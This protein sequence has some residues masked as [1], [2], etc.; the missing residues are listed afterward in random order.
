MAT[1]NFL[2]R[3]SVIVLFAISLLAGSVYSQDIFIRVNQA[4]YL[5]EDT[6]RAIAF[7]RE[8]LRD[9]NFLVRTK[10]SVMFVGKVR[11]I[12]SP[13]WGGNFTYFYELDLS[14]VRNVGRYTIQLVN[15]NTVSQEFQ[16]GDYPTYQE[17]LLFFMRQQRCGYNPFLDAVCHKRDGRS[18]YAPFPDGTFVD[19]SGGWH[20]AGDQ[21]KY[22]ITASNA[23]ARMMLAYELEKRKFS[24]TV[25]ALG[26][27]WPNGIPD[28][29]DEAKWGLD[30]IHKLHPAKD[31][32]I[33]QVADDR[34]HRG[35]KLPDQDNADY[36][37]GPNSYRPAYFADGK[38]QGLGQYKSRSTGVANIAG[39]SAAAMA[40]ADRLWR[41]DIKDPMFAAE[42]LKD[43]EELYANGQATGRLST[44]QFVRSS[45]PLQR[46]YLGGRYGMGRSGII[47]IDTKARLFG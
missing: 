15:A 5:P 35:F 10:S 20:D 8:P 33:H 18:F 32:L 19:A 38:P 46:R 13:G 34:D 45:L 3:R 6:K 39:R 25:D 30:W 40:M 22:L 2:T 28:V 16:I 47:Q 24:D 29:L 23:T 12:A 14:L 26:R 7:S 43:A 9:T 21:L 1:M 42:C 37:W 11:P 36:G 4:G 17:D 31:L 27:P 41:L 44:R